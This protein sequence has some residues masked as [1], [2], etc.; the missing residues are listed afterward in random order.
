MQIDKKMKN[1]ILMRKCHR[2]P[3][4]AAGVNG[5]PLTLR[6]LA[7]INCDLSAVTQQNGWN[8][9]SPF[10]LKHAQTDSEVTCAAFFHMHKI[11]R[12]CSSWPDDTIVI[13]LPKNQHS[14]TN[15]WFWCHESEST[16]HWQ[17]V[18]ITEHTELFTVLKDKTRLN[19]II[20]CAENDKY[21][22]VLNS[23]N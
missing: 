17:I 10:R 23:L 4:V 13:S 15:S 5:S 8:R 7:D 19:W 1:S 3:H 20:I 12:N 11:D 21:F 6:Y 22:V 2:F 18:Q 14:A 16:H 9:S